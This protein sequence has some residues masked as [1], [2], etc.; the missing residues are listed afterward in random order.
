M[1]YPLLAIYAFFCLMTGIAIGFNEEK[2]WVLVAFLVSGLVA[3]QVG[4]FVALLLRG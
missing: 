2:I 3:I 4:F 1:T